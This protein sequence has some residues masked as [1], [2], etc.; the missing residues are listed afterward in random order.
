MKTERDCTSR[1][2]RNREALEIIFDKQKQLGH[3]H[4][5]YVE[6]RGIREIE[7]EENKNKA[8]KTINI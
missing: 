6:A 4:E 3:K 1:E 8:A 2:R 5:K 7:G